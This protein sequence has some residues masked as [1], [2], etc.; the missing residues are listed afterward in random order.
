M[1]KH[2]KLN[3]I[4][5]VAAFALVLGA[6]PAFAQYNSAPQ[7]QKSNPGVSSTNQ[8]AANSENAKSTADDAFAQKAAQG[9]MAEVKLGQL[10]EQRGTNPAVK[11]F[12]KRMVQDHSKNENDLKTTASRENVVLPSG[13]DKADQATYDRLS[14]LNGEAF[15]RAYARDMV[16]DHTK[17]IAEFQKEAKDGHNDAIKNY[18]AQ[19]V[20]VLQTHLELARKM[21]ASVTQS[22]RN[23]APSNG[24]TYPSNNTVPATR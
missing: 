17:D 24:T 16:K 8:Q 6:G 14:K 7:T 23:N 5:G 1:A 19:T 22:A 4:T 3:F 2:S 21:D 9:D 18:A 10:A 20:P 11:D 12:G 15:D 13:V